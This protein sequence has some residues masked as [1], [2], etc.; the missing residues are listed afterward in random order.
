MQGINCFELTDISMMALYTSLLFSASAPPTNTRLFPYL[1]YCG[2]TASS[3]MNAVH[4]YTPSR[5]V[6]VNKA[7]FMF[8]SGVTVEFGTCDNERTEC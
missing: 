6:S 4:T 8:L 1:W 5:R 3:R 2:S 7:E